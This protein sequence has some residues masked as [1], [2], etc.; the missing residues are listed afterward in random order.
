MC[1]LK[2][3]LPP[4]AVVAESRDPL[5]G[6]GALHPDEVPFMARA[7][8]KR[9]RDF[10]AGRTCAR[11]ALAGLGFGEVAVVPGPSREPQWP[12][13]VAGSIT[14]AHGYVAAAVGWEA[15]IG[16]IGIDAEVLAPLE[17][18][19]AALVCTPAELRWIDAEAPAGVEWA[20]VLFSA[21]EAVFKAW[22]PVMHRSLDF[23]EVEVRVDPRSG[24]FTAV[25]AAS[26]LERGPIAGRFG[27]CRGYV[28][29]SARWPPARARPSGDPSGD[30]PLAWDP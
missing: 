8:E 30:Q 20:T 15:Q 13:G 2:D 28:M 22:F 12:P 29:A 6:Y 23:Q 14:H 11:R 5:D 18:G 16:S 17:P 26:V 4:G 1:G 9:R 10:T 7:V 21:K 19:V 3:I 24:A 25:P 27:I